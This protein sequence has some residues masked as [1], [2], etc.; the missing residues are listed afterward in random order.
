MVVMVVAMVVVVVVVTVVVAAV[1]V[2]VVMA[3]VVVGRGC[4]NTAVGDGWRQR[5]TRQRVWH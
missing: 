3:E 1:V 4:C 2:A 5:L